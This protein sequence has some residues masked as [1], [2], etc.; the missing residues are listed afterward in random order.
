[1]KTIYADLAPQSGQIQFADYKV[2]K[3]SQAQIPY[4]RRKLGIVFQDFQLLPDRSVYENI[5]FAL[6]A[7]GASNEGKIRNR[8]EELLAKVGMQGKE[9]AMPHQI[10]GGEQQRVVIARALINDPLLLLADEPTG[11]LDPEMTDTIMQ[12][13]YKINLSG[14]AILMV[15]H[16][17]TLLK[18][19]PARAFYLTG[20][21]LLEYEKSERLIQDLY[22]V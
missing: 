18:K 13:L 3:I 22:G 2:E 14:T 9:K 8:V 10:S 4:L 6:R 21:T 5:A 1:M 12:L 19:Y 20:K 11:N 17:H 7:C 16:E 15:T